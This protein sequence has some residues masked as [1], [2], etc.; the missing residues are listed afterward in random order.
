MRAVVAPR[1]EA[2]RRLEEEIEEV[3][4]PDGDA[5]DEL[6]AIDLVDGLEPVAQPEHAQV[7]PDPVN[8][9]LVAAEE[10]AA[11][12]RFRDEVAMSI[13]LV[14]FPFT[15]WPFSRHGWIG[16]LVFANGVACHMGNGLRLERARELAL[17]D[18]AWNLALCLFVNVATH[19]Q[20]M[21]GIMTA[22]VLVVWLSNGGWRGVWNPWVHIFGVQWMLC[23]LLFVYEYGR[24]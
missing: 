21:T 23:A 15:A 17:W 20:P 6:A 24:K 8:D 13:A 2:P 1:A 22:F 18:I 3:A 11:R 12:K 14:P 5:D 4:D 7:E 10:Q 16:W 19:W 9:A